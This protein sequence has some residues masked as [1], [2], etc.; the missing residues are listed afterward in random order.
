M[1]H[2]IDHF[3]NDVKLGK[4]RVTLH[5]IGYYITYYCITYY[6]FSNPNLADDSNSGDAKKR[7]MVTSVEATKPF[8]PG[9]DDESRTDQKEPSAELGEVP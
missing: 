7:K 9:D 8:E 2:A 5:I 3:Y 1:K 6:S 4:I